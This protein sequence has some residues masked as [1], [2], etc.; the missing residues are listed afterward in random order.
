[1]R[2]Q[3]IK[4]CAQKV[5]FSGAGTFRSRERRGCESRWWAVDQRVGPQAGMC[6]SAGE[7]TCVSTR[8]C[9]WVRVCVCACGRFVGWSG[10][11][12]PGSSWEEKE[13]APWPC[14]VAGE[15]LSL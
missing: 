1:M 4:R 5:C 9:A 6:L 15:G 11:L 14:G 13:E 3:R 10:V 8:T 2:P 7:W 12:G